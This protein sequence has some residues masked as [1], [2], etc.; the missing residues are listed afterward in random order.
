MHR[1]W[2]QSHADGITLSLHIVPRASATAAAGLHGQALKLRVQAPPAEGKAN[3]ALT[4]FLA[5]RLQ[6][7]ARAI[8]IT[9]GAGSREKTVHARGVSEATA[10]LAL[11]PPGADGN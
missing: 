11:L 3:K 7:P 2:I 6:C 8:T 5:D 9:G 10:R 4:A 1:D